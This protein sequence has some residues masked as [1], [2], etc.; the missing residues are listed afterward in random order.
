MVT[1]A[2]PVG[3]GRCRGA[4]AYVVVDYRKPDL[5]GRQRVR[6]RDGVDLLGDLGPPRPPPR[7]RSGGPCSRVLLS[8][9]VGEQP[10]ISVQGIYTRIVSLR[11]FISSRVTVSELA[12]ASRLIN[13]MLVAGESSARITEV[14]P[15]GAAAE[16]R[17]RLKPEAV[18]G[19]L[20]LR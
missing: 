12:D 2:R 19:H 5:A 6:A 3:H 16:F 4:G 18:T 8:A 13:M 17:T 20:L 14:L 1:S 10:E 7:H 15:L 11:S 9:A